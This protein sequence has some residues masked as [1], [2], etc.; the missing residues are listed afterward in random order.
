[1]DPA[2]DRDDRTG[3]ASCGSSLPRR[4][5]ERTQAEWAEVFDGTDACVA[6]VLPL[7]EAAEHPHLDARGTYVEQDGVLS[8]RP[9]HGSRGPG[10]R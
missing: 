5:P 8:R 3:S 2:P 9:R 1:M 7:T 6:P 4:F 10:R